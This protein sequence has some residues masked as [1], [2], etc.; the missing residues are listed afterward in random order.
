MSTS[1]TTLQ[2][3]L[4]SGTLVVAPGAYD[5]LSARLVA[6]AGFP[7]IYMTGF[8]ATAA[9]IGQPDIGLL[10]Q[11]EMTTHARDM[12]RAV[13]IPVIADADTGY[14][15]PSNIERTVQEYLQAGVAAIHLEDQVAPKRCGQMAGI[16]LIDAE[17]NARRLRCAVAARGTQPLL[18]IGRTDALPAMGM[19]EA[20]ARAQ[21]YQ[22]AG[23]DLVF[24]DGVKTVAEVEGIARR[25]AGPKVI[26]IVDGTDAARLAVPELQAMGF[27][28]A[29]FAV[30]AL[31]T[32]ARAVEVA[33]RELHAKGTPQGLSQPVMTYAEFTEVVDLAHHQQLDG[34]Y[35][36]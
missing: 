35:G 28:L 32:A 4:A 1:Y 15:G 13:N 19:D 5:A 27:Q 10:T 22:D 7:A 30:T 20:V 23:V 2:N 17:E 9:R 25:V 21:R 33:L 16:R 29:F 6:R 34:A 36:G 31:F 14:G 11:T 3:A 18:L 26:S 12:V 24:V 8:G